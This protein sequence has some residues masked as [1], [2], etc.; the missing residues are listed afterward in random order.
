MTRDYASLQRKPFLTPLWLSFLSA[1]IAVAFLGFATWA[2]WVWATANCTTIIVVRH[3]EKVM[4]GADP[5]LAPAGEARAELLSRMFGNTRGPTRVD[6]IYASSAQRSRL[7]AAPLAA[8][9]GIIVIVAS[10][11]PGTLAHRVLREHP[12]G[13]VLIVGHGDTVPKIV[14]ALSGADNVPPIADDDFG[15]MY[16]VSVPRIGRAN[17]LRETY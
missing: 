5:P 12:G 8:R 16:V 14:R 9:L 2:A 15:T 3:A 6:A 13:R 7:T 4:V 1:V 10:A 17:V 11:D